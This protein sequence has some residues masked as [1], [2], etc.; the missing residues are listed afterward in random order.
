MTAS[1]VPPTLDG[2]I[3]SHHMNRAAVASFAASRP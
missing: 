1:V 2:A 3:A